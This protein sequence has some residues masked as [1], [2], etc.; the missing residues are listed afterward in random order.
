VDHRWF[1]PETL[2][3]SAERLPWILPRS[4]APCADS[5]KNVMPTFSSS[6]RI[7]KASSHASDRHCNV[8][9][10]RR[11]AVTFS[12]LSLSVRFQSDG[13]LHP[14]RSESDVALRHL[15]IAW[16]MVEP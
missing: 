6:L 4:P 2:S 14:R 3:Q 13:E 12:H 8:D 15:S 16:S 11:L 9:S 1:R 5:G 10:T 7:V